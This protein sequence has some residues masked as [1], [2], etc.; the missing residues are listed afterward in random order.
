M[1]NRLHDG[2]STLAEIKFQLSKQ[3]SDENPVVPNIQPIFISVDPSRDTPEVVGKYIKEFSP[4]F[5]GLTGSLEQVDKVCK[6]F[7]VYYSAGPPDEDKDYIVS[8]SCFI[9]IVFNFLLNLMDFIYQ[10]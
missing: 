8:N 9:E 5:I 1:S 7:R 10:G 4:K 3:F 2:R 6:A